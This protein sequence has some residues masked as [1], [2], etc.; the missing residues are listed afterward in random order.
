MGKY[1]VIPDNKQIGDLWIASYPVVKEI[2]E[3]NQVI[4]EDFVGGIQGK[5]VCDIFALGSR[6]LE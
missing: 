5:V 3:G 1:P 4:D 2:L 6:H